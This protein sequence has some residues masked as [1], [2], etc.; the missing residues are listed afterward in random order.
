MD[1]ACGFRPERPRGAHRYSVS[2]VSL[3]NRYLLRSQYTDG[4]GK[5]APRNRWTVG[6]RFPRRPRHGRA[7][8]SLTRSLT[9]GDDAP[10]VAIGEGRGAA[11][12]PTRLVPRAAARGEG[13]ARHDGRG[14]VGSG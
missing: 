2:A 9:A 6:S 4:N 8:A 14:S 10:S 1:G 13:R 7:R 11:A 5:G 3:A 12:G